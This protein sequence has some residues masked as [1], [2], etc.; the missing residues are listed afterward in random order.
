MPP[1]SPC[2]CSRQAKVPLPVPGC[3]HCAEASPLQP[4]WRVTQSVARKFNRTR[5]AR[6]DG[7]AHF[8]ACCI[9]CRIEMTEQELLGAGALRD[10]AYV[11]RRRMQR[12]KHRR[13]ARR[14]EH[15]AVENQH[16][17]VLRQPRER[18]M[19]RRVDIAAER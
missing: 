2:W 8:I 15:D 12:V 18:R 6:L 14:I 17:R 3:A 16:I 11:A 4:S 19:T 13:R 1:T 10:S 9:E 5:I 7:G